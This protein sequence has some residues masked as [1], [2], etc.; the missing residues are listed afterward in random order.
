MEAKPKRAKANESVLG[1]G[2]DGLSQAFE[3]ACRRAGI[4]GLRLHDLRHEATSRLFE[5]GL[6]MMEVSAITGHKT[7][8][9]LKRYT[10]MCQCFETTAGLNLVSFGDGC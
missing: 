2:P 9:M 10:G 7:L 1:F 6:D 4:V 5:L 3:R 8:D